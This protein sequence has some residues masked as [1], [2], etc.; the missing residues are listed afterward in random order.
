[1]MPDVCFMKYLEACQRLLGLSSSSERYHI[2]M[3]Q[4]KEAFK[5]QVIFLKLKNL[6]L[7]VKVDLT[8]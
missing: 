4:R 7:I 5:T 2:S 3:A 6:K 1:M 8:A